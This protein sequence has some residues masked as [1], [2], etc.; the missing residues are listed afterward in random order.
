MTDVAAPLYSFDGKSVWV[1]GHNGLVGQAIVRR[2]AEEGCKVLTA[3]RS[4]MDQRNQAD[5]EAWMADNR[6][7]AV[8]L[9]AGTVGGIFAN[10]TR[11][12]EFIYDNLA[13][14]TNVINAAWK[15]GVEKFMFLGSACI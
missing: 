10:D 15:T 11:P 9:A 5:V 4:E 7:D 14:E 1:S 12:A 2:L 6:P 8:F 3:E 13:I